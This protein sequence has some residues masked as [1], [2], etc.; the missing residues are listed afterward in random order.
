MSDCTTDISGCIQLV[1]LKVEQTE[2]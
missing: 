1:R 2:N